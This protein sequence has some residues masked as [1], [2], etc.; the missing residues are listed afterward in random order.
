MIDNR[1]RCFLA[2]MICAVM[3][4]GC[5]E[6]NDGPETFPVSGTVTYNGEPMAAGDV[7]FRPADGQGQSWAGKIENGKFSLDSTA[8][9][10]KIEI[11]AFKEAPT[12]SQFADSGEGASQVQ[13]V[14]AEYNTDSTLKE[15]V[16]DS[17][18]NEFTF[19]LKGE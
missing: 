18:A 14:P 10:K 6:N 7:V 16:S 11:T 19:E 3:F 5:G 2:P 17:G 13:Y 9:E 1:V 15:T 8:G 4:L 12:P